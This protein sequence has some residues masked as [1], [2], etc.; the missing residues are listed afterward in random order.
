MNPQILIGLTATAIYALSGCSQHTPYVGQSQHP[1]SQN[2]SYNQTKSLATRKAVPQRQIAPK[3]QV[4]PRRHVRPQ[5]QVAPQRQAATQRHLRPQRQVAPTKRYA[6]PQRQ[7]SRQP[8]AP[9]HQHRPAPRQ[10]QKVGMPNISAQEVRRIGD[11][12][13]Q[14]E[15]GGDV[16]KLVHWNKGE[17]FASMGIGHFTW[18]PAARKQRYGNTFPGMLSYLE[19]R[20]VRLPGWVQKAKHSGAPWRT[21]SQL[22]RD[23]NNP[24]VQQLQRILFETRYLQ[25]EYI[26]KRAQRAMPKLVTTAPP[27][28]RPMVS[29][30]LNAVANS[31]G[32]WYPLIDYVNFK[33]EG[34]SRHGGYK[35]QNWGLLQV[36]EEMR[37]TT[38]GQ[39]ALHEF[40]NAASR[41]LTR[42][43]KNSPRSRNEARWLAGWNNRIST[44]RKAS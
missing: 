26:M 25:A 35:G 39:G 7:A 37:P 13:F 34:L 38:P 33:G 32:G 40:A 24:Q 36:L 3:R 6:P 10:Q 19:S 14:N 31:R 18:Y 4:V 12:I 16:N 9:P 8:I 11:Q 43:V 21:R 15:S 17:D 30:N 23:K 2:V 27:H 28:L 5:R 44:Y 29:N 42:R 22:M 20:G 41:V 1:A